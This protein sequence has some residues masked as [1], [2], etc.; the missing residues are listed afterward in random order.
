MKTKNDIFHRSLKSYLIRP[1]LSSTATCHQLRLQVSVA[2]S[3]YTVLR[4]QPLGCRQSQLYPVFTQGK[5]IGS[6]S[7]RHF[8]EIHNGTSVCDTFHIGI[9]CQRYYA[10]FC[11]LHDAASHIVL[12]VNSVHGSPILKFTQG[13][14]HIRVCCSPPPPLQQ[15]STFLSEFGFRSDYP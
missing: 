9:L 7:K 13:L 15:P 12:R 4:N 8:S 1:Y 3:L 6:Y 14:R 5:K 10:L 2:F 11:V